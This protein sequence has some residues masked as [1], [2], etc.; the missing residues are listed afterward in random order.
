MARKRI[1]SLA[2]VSYNADPQHNGG[3]G[4]QV[5]RMGESAR[6]VERGRADPL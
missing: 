4:W 1:R 6:D 5:R 3:N 2:T